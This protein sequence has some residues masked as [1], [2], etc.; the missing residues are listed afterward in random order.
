MDCSGVCYALLDGSSHNTIKNSMMDQ[1]TNLSGWPVGVNIRNNSQYNQLL[2]NTIGN[3]GY[4]SSNDDIGAV[5]DIG[6]ID[7]T[8][9]D[10]SNYNL[11]Q[12]NTLFHGGHHVLSIG[13]SNNVIKGNYIHN[14]EW[15][16]CTRTGSERKMWRSTR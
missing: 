11:F 2:N 8:N 5:V 4:S 3:V 15:N 10:G 9:F 7:N 13:S 16:T 12:D 14:E 6:N 1:A